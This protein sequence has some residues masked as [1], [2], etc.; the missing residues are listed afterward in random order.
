[1]QA[2]NAGADVAG[3]YLSAVCVPPLK[4]LYRIVAEVVSFW[5]WRSAPKAQDS[6]P[7][8]E[9]A[10]RMRPR[11]F[12]EDTSECTRRAFDKRVIGAGGGN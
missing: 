3:D 11:A 10:S 2:A 9:R 7:Q 6:C 4:A 5:L 8:P 1:V 12:N